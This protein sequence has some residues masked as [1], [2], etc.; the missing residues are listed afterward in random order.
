M[1]I[2]EI[3]IT[4][5]YN[6]EDREYFIAPE[7]TFEQKIL[8]AQVEAVAERIALNDRRRRTI[9]EIIL[10]RELLIPMLKQ[11]AQFGVTNMLNW[12]LDQGA[13]Y[14]LERKELQEKVNE[15]REKLERQNRSLPEGYAERFIPFP[16]DLEITIHASI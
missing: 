1:Q 9:Q 15:L 8:Q 5:Y 10:L 11:L 2:E 6:D 4:R 3:P 7:P 14:H 12:A 13:Q 16:L